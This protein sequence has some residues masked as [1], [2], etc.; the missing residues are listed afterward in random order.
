MWEYHRSDRSTLLFITLTVVSFILMT[1]DVRTAGEGVTGTLREGSQALLSPVQGV[2]SS[3]ASPIADLVDGLANVAGL[4]SENERLRSEIE[5]LRAQV[6]K[7]ED[8]ESDNA[9]LR[10]VLNLSLPEELQTRTVAARV[11][12]VGPSS[13]DYSVVIDKG[14]DDG[15]AVDMAVVD[16]L[17]L[18]GRI[19]TVTEAS[20]KVSLIIDPQQSVAVRAARSRDLGVVQGRGAGHLALTL[21]EASQPLAEGDRIVTAGSD[22]YPPDLSVGAV[23]AAARPQGGFLLRTKVRPAVEFNRLDYVKV[24]LWTSEVEESAEAPQAGGGTASEGSQDGP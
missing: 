24:I 21:F 7:L 10:A 12:S 1:L 5:S 3:V 8:L 18:V 23:A 22:L 13:F 20:A 19:A 6:G 4:R 9:E 16:E 14:L 2:I 17:G 11:M 15:V